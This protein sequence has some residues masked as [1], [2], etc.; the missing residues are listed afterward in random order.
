MLSPIPTSSMTVLA[1][2]SPGWVQ[3]AAPATLADHAERLYQGLDSCRHTAEFMTITF[4]CT[5][6][7]KRVSPAVVHVD[8]TARAQLVTPEA[9][10]GLY[11]IIDEYRKITGIPSVVNTSFNMHESP[12]VATPE[13]AIESFQEGR[14]DYLAIGPFLVEGRHEGTE[15]RRHEGESAGRRSFANV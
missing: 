13:D 12:I 10:P 2:H 14:L 15:A 6:E 5:P 3:T 1:I 9:N 8:G 7:M 11:E 4:D